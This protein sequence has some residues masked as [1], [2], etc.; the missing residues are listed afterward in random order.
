M[1]HAD[2]AMI[3]QA[4]HLPFAE[5][6]FLFLRYVNDFLDGIRVSHAYNL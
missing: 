1:T 5:Q 2:I 6:P 4:G 3:P